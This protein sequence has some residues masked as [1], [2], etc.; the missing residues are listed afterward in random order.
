MPSTRSVAVVVVNANSGA[1]VGRTLDALAQ[2]T[3]PPQ[4]TI[5][6][7]NASTDGST[8]E[9][10]RAHP[11]VE[12]VRLDENVGFAAANNL[13]ARLAE[14]CDWIATLNPDA[15]PEP[16]WLAALL[17][18]ADAHPE[19][20]S[21]GSRLV[22]AANDAVLDGTGD[23]YHVNGFAWRRDHG[24]PAA[25]V[26]RSGEVFSPCAAAAL[27]RR[28]AFLAVGGFDEAF[29]CYF[30]DTDLAFRLRLL[31]HRCLYV[32]DAVALHVGS[33][34]TGRLS[35]FTLFHQYRNCVW[36]YAKDMPWP[37]LVAYLP[38]H[39][40]TQLLLLAWG[41]R[42]RRARVVLRA[43]W[44]ALRGLPAVLVRRRVVQGRRVVGVRE[45][46][47]SMARGASAYVVAA[48]RARA[49]S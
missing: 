32:D 9:I 21:F 29:F 22:S 10:A 24:G 43:Q 14:D 45:L 19:Y 35:D 17:D 18:A 20:A 23:R 44:A 47:R 15:F 42:R 16:G 46:R 41:L 39:V 40:L 37:L 1:H 12:L 8:D 27:Y 31:G 49:A 11:A 13:G 34:S 26:R 5:V 38:Q 7:D 33:A 3:V 25:T 28:D 36:T 48:G 30:E 6:V 4:R 2:Q